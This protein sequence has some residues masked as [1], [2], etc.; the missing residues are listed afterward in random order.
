MHACMHDHELCLANLHSSYLKQLKPSSVS[1]RHKFCSVMNSL[2]RLFGAQILV[3]C[4]SIVMGTVYL[5]NSK[6]MGLSI[7]YAVHR[8]NFYMCISLALLKLDSCVPCSKL[9]T[10]HAAELRFGNVCSLPPE[11]Q[12]PLP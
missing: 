4:Y 6:C 3:M 1:L 11:L 9:L 5:F 12:S 8:Q 10:L 7:T 2:T